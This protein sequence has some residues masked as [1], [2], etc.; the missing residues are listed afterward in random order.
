MASLI[1]WLRVLDR[2]PTAPDLEIFP[3]VGVKDQIKL[4]I[5]LQTGNNTGENAREIV[6]IGDRTD[7]ILELKGFQD[8]YV[9]RFLPPNKLEYK[10]EGL[11]EL[12]SVTVYRT[13]QIDLEV[14]TYNDIYKSFDPNINPSV[15]SEKLQIRILIKRNFQTFKK[16][17]LMT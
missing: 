1:Q 6:S 10:N 12:R 2:P 16:S 11:S 14:D 9:N 17:L 13:T 3:M 4:L 5:N 15:L 8:T 7:K